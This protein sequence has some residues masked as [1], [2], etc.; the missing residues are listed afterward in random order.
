VL[1]LGGGGGGRSGQRGD[2]DGDGGRVA[3]FAHGARGGLAAGPPEL[4][5]FGRER[6]LLPARRSLSRR[7]PP[8]WDACWAPAAAVPDFDAR[9][10]GR[11]APGGGN[12]GSG[13]AEEGGP[14]ERQPTIGRSEAEEEQQQ[15]Q[16]EWD[17][18]W[19]PDWAL[20]GR[21]PAHAP[22]AL[23]GAGQLWVGLRS[24][25]LACVELRGSRG[26]EPWTSLA[27]LRA[28]PIC[29]EWNPRASLLVAGCAD[30]CL[31]VLAPVAGAAAARARERQGERQGEADAQT[32]AEAE[33]EEME[34]AD[35][36][37]E[38]AAQGAD[39]RRA[40]AHTHGALQPAAAADQP[41]LRP[42]GG[43]ARP[44]RR[45]ARPAPAQA[46]GGPPAAPTPAED[47][48]GM[49]GMQGL[50]SGAP[51]PSRVA[52]AAAAAG[53]SGS[54]ARPA[55][56]AA[57]LPV[58][59][60]EGEM[61]PWMDA[62]ANLEPRGPSGSLSATRA[63]AT[64]GG[65]ASCVPSACA[66]RPASAAAPRPLAVAGPARPL[67]RQSSLLR[68][69]SGGNAMRSDRRPAAAALG[70]SARSAA[71]TSRDGDPGGSS[72]NQ[73]PAASNGGGKRATL[74]DFWK[75]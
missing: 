4:S 66:P 32:E 41:D 24:A 7:A 64:A 70:S 3:M 47:D 61:E 58:R 43:D 5:A 19:A 55:S 62:R 53:R 39:V 21:R 25:G 33:E 8:P 18:G 54:C 57:A 6:E 48:A 72:E 12:G 27:E 59:S 34:E 74:L 44:A 65:S 35:R 40:L 30:N 20:G 2:N 52:A 63:E 31:A 37:A 29:L 46:G 60:R 22:G 17:P 26:T 16:P 68:A 1:V 69:Q 42:A 15:Q 45:D 13:S 51:A 28:P 36:Q 50:D 71:E 14:R 75:R 11:Y 10:D 23:G 67:V 38:A 49:G 73:V 56:E 9:T